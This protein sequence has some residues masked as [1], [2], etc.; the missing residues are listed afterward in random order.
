MTIVSMVVAAAEDNAIGRDNDLLWH[1]PDDFKFFKDTTIGHP[2]VMG[3]KTFQAL[4][5]ALPKRLNIVITR[6]ADFEAPGAEVVSS[7]DDALLLAKNTNDP[8]I[9][10]IGGAEIYRL[11]LPLTN[12]VYL[13]RVHAHFP[14]ADA[15]FPELD[16][17]EWR[18]VNTSFHDADERHQYGFTFEVWERTGR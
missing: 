16:A 14:D 8:E 15:H 11:A 2:I 6:Q 1:L 13:T 10:V 17:T 7:L 9:M 3:R 5:K 4:G 12:R 18:L